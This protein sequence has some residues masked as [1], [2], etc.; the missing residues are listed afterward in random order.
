[1][2]SVRA[3]RPKTF[4]LAYA[5][6][7]V[8]C[9]YWLSV[10]PQVRREA[11]RWHERAGQIP[12]PSLRRVALQTERLKKANIQGAAAFAILAPPAHRMAV[13]RASVAF[14]AMYD[15]ADT[16]A[17]GPSEDPVLNAAQLHQTLL[18]ALDDNA[19]HVDYYAHHPRR[20]DGGY[21]EEMVDTC[22]SGLRALP[23]YPLIAEVA[24]GLGRRFVRYQSLN[25]S[26]HLGDHKSL[27]QWARGETP[28]D[29]GLRWWETA[30]STGSSL[31]LFALIAAAAR[32]DLTPA[33]AAAISEAYWPWAGALHILLD[34]V[35]DEALDAAAGQRSLLDY[36]ASPTQAASRLQLLAREAMRSMSELPK[37]HQHAVI[38]A[39]M[40]ASYLSSASPLS[41]RA[42]LISQS[43]LEAM[44]P[45]VKPSIFIFR[46]RHRA[47]CVHDAG[48]R[49]PELKRATHPSAREPQARARP[50]RSAP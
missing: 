40:V 29:S 12:D 32:P 38:L 39:G 47:A 19:H 5:N 49:Y 25:L 43:V 6:A 31:G 34:S 48:S 45:T 11:C 4:A 2:A 17:E 37:S 21:L 23:S 18:G 44:G 41:T 16:L 10:I 13:V 7:T 46:V 27:A 15:Y 9:Q 22:R 50:T 14:Q 1:M 35:A 20:D 28:A 3:A 36:Y 24:A 30:A 26:E 33:E 42:Q 8:H